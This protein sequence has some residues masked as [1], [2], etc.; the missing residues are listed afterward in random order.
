[1][2]TT[3]KR[4]LLRQRCD[5]DDGDNIGFIDNHQ[6]LKYLGKDDVGEKLVIKCH[7]DILDE[8]QHED[9]GDNEQSSADLQRQYD[10]I[11]SHNVEVKAR[12]GKKERGRKLSHL[13]ER[14]PDL[15]V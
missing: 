9:E 4:T 7:E 3:K 10:L 12:K 14:D 13:C 11:F 15:K 6:S 8:E 2:T 5:Q 1:M